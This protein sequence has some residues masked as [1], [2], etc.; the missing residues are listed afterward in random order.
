MQYTNM[1]AAI[2]TEYAKKAAE[3]SAYI[4]NGHEG[5]IDSGLIRYCTNA[6]FTAYTE[7]RITR[8]QAIEYATSRM[9]KGIEKDKAEDINKLATIENAGT[10]TEATISIEWK[11]SAMWGNNPTSEL[12]Y[13]YHDAENNDKWGRIHGS[14][15]GGC[16]YDKESASAAQVLN[17]CPECLKPLYDARE[18]NMSA[19]LRGVLGYGSG[20]RNNPYFEGGVGIGCFRSIYE[21]LGYKWENVSSGKTFDVYRIS[22]N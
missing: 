6:R 20:Y 21:K 14:S 16:G 11:R 9:M 10:L 22:K 19:D 2:E 12:S 17:Q 1:R 4:V 5:L 3:Q 13:S 18:M 8:E 7:G 15:I